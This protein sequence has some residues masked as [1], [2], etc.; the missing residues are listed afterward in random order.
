MLQEHELGTLEIGHKADMI[1]IN[2]DQ[3]HIQ[4]THNLLNTL[5]ESVNSSDVTDVI[6]DGKLLMK[7][8][9]VLTLDEEKIKYESKL[10][11]KELSIRA[12]I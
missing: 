4:P 5:I 12:D 10:A 1:M 9:E 6:V 7:N 11:L 2:I 3:P 8:R